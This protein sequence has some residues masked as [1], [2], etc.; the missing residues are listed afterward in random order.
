MLDIC[1]QEN[2]K[3]FVDLSD[4]TWLTKLEYLTDIFQELNLFN[5]SFQS[6]NISIMTSTD[7]INAFQK[8]LTIR[9]KQ[10]ASGN[11]ETFS[12]IVE[13]NYQDILSLVL[14]HLDTFSDGLNK[15]FQSISADQYD[16]VRTLFV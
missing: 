1:L 16:C 11:F 7:T 15:Y 6:R 5:N 12:S 13:T 9:K 10:A 14:N 8:N 2:L 4:K 3:D